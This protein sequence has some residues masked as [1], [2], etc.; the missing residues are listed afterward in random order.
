MKRSEFVKIDTFHTPL[1]EKI[2]ENGKISNKQARGIFIK[3][4]NNDKSP[5]E[6]IKEQGSEMVSDEAIV[7]AIVK[8]TI[9][10]NPQAVI[11]Y[12]NGKDRAVGFLVGKIMKKS[13]GKANPA[14]ANKLVI[15]E[16]K[17]R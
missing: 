14:L 8:E 7:M 2:I 10:E 1:Y 3:M 16:L 12:K 5:S 9:N 17:R 13:N 4:L 11:D 6:L 15:E